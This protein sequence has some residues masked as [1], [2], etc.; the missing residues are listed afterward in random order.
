MKKLQKTKAYK[1]LNQVARDKSRKKSKRSKA[2]NTKKKS[3][4]YW[5]ESTNSIK[6]DV[7]IKILNLFEL[8]NCFSSVAPISYEY[9]WMYV[10][11]LKKL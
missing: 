9:S 7:E 5:M 1:R 2:K 4:N 10:F 3:K 11:R 8:I 6:K